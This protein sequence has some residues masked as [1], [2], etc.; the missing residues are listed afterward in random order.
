MG[1][2]DGSI[3]TF[4][5]EVDKI[6]EVFDISPNRKADALR[7]QQLKVKE[8]L[9]P[10]EIQEL[11]NLTIL[12]EDFL[13]TPTLFNTFGS[14]VVALEK[15][16]LE[17]TVGFIEEMKQ[18]VQVEIDKFQHRGT[19]NIDTQYFQRNTVDYD[20]GTGVKVY[21]ALQNTLGNVPTN[22]TFWKPLTIQGQ[23][24]QRGQDGVGVIPKGLWSSTT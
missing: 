7:F 1:F 6:R 12:L 10:S 23:R 9:T 8:N 24:G 22:N 19:Y 13:I 4:P 5:N 2:L 3:S 20:D 18:D 21:I 16:F 15:F 11:N 14:A 17:E